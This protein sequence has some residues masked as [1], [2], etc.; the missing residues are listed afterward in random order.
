PPERVSIAVDK[1]A[2]VR[3]A[4]DSLFA[5]ER[6]DL[7]GRLVSGTVQSNPV[8]EIALKLAAATAPYWHPAAAVPVDADITAV[9]RGLK[10][11]SPKPWPERFRELQAAGGRIEFTNAR[12]RQRDTIATATGSLGLS[13]A[14]R[15]DGQL[16]L[17]VANLDQL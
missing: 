2:V 1:T 4:G 14:G 17:T 3:A 7:D 16:N 8:I 11:F 13:P 6:V 12:V 9:L 10:D 15:L 5:A